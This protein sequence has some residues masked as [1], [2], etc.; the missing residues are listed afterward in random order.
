M[1]KTLRQQFRSDF[2]TIRRLLNQFDPCDLI[3]SGAPEDEYD[4]LTHKIISLAYLG[5]ARKDIENEILSD[6]EHRFGFDI[7]IFEDNRQIEVQFF[8]EMNVLLNGVDIIR[9]GH[10]ASR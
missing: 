2:L 6:L 7:G 4:D 1:D 10:P 8:E 9:D 5:R 3:L